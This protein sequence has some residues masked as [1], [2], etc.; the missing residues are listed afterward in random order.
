M[1]M[2]RSCP[3]N[4]IH[5]VMLFDGL[6]G[7]RC[8]LENRKDYI[9]MLRWYVPRFD[10]AGSLIQQPGSREPHQGSYQRGGAGQEL[11]VGKLKISSLTKALPRMR[12][13][14]PIDKEVLADRSLVLHFC[15]IRIGH[16]W[17]GTERGEN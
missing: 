13:G 14:Q 2:N 15:S 11:N 12:Q 4:P 8:V 16:I 6:S 10:E 3:G 7:Q 5:A 17:K 1:K 9:E